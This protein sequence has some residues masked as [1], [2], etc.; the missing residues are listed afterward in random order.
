LKINGTEITDSNL[1]EFYEF[2]EEEGLGGTNPSKKLLMEYVDDDDIVSE[3]TGE[4]LVA[5]ASNRR[6]YFKEHEDEI[7]DSFMENHCCESYKADDTEFDGIQ[8]SIGRTCEECHNESVL[9][10]YLKPEFNKA[11]MEN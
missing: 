2:R 9:I 4:K 1:E 7:W 8:A 6:K 10:F 3:I 5:N 11:K